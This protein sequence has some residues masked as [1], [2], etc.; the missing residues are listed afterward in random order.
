MKEGTTEGDVAAPEF[1][2]VAETL[3]W[4]SWRLLSECTATSIRISKSDAKLVR[5]CDASTAQGRNLPR[6]WDKS[7][8]IVNTGGLTQGLSQQQAIQ[9]TVCTQH[10]T[11]QDDFGH[12][13]FQNSNRKI[14]RY[15][16]RGFIQLLLGCLFFNL[17]DEDDMFLRNVVWLWTDYTALYPRI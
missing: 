5:T 8:R 3:S 12:G 16:Y 7:F 1:S 13:K 14:L 4:S 9:C 15:K 6:T 2:I 11:I 10:S 17:D